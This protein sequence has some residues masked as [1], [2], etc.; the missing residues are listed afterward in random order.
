MS[1]L[2]EVAV[3]SSSIARL[4]L[5]RDKL[6]F[7]VLLIKPAMLGSRFPHCLLPAVEYAVWPPNALLYELGRAAPAPPGPIFLLIAGE[8]ILAS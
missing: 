7:L 3:Y 8:S 4:G 2:I 1:P 6:V 5:D